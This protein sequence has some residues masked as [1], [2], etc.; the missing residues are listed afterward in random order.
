MN[1][2][3][4]LMAEAGKEFISKNPD[5]GT[6]DAAV[7]NEWG[8]RYNAARDLARD[9]YY[10]KKEAAQAAANVGPNTC[11]CTYG[12]V[13]HSLARQAASAYVFDMA[14]AR[15]ALDAAKR[16]AQIAATSAIYGPPNSKEARDALREAMSSF[17]AKAI[18]Y[19][20]I[21]KSVD[22]NPA[23][24]AAAAAVSTLSANQLPPEKRA[25]WLNSDNNVFS[26]RMSAYY[27]AHNLTQAGVSEA[28]ANKLVATV[29]AQTQSA[30]GSTGA[31]PVAPPKPPKKAPKKPLKKPK[32]RK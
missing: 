31:T 10:L 9:N 29:V 26:P 7:Y 18:Y 24:M 13:E 30:T 19:N 20:R 1:E 28:E 8:A 3:Q 14:N 16:E 5:P 2:L 4:Q 23:V 22:E 6:S 15:R 12:S 17:K 21:Q 27:R 25:A 11:N 32:G